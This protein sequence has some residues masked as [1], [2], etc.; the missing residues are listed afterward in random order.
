MSNENELKPIGRS[1]TFVKALLIL[2]T[3][4]SAQASAGAARALSP[5]DGMPTS[6]EIFGYVQDI[7]D[8]G[9]RRTGSQANIETASYIADKFRQAGLTDV[10]I[11]KGKTYQWS[12]TKWGLEAGGVESPAF[13]MRHSF[14]RGQAGPFR[15]PQG[16]LKAPLI[17][18]GNKKDL[19]GIDVKGKIV[20]A[21][22]EL[23]QLDM[24]QILG[25]AT[26]VHDPD[27]TLP[28]GKKLDPFTPNNFPYN[29]ASAMKG[30]AVG[31]VGVLNNYIDSN[32]FYNEDLD[33]F[34]DDKPMNIPG[35]WVTKKDGERLKELARRSSGAQASLVLEGSVD[36]V[37]YRTV[38][39]FLPGRSPET[40]MVQS[41]HDSGFAGAVEDA[42]GTAAVIA[43][44][45][46]Y[47][48]QPPRS[49]KRSL[50]FAVMDTH[51]TGY[52]S[53]VD[54]AKKFILSQAVDVVANVTVEHIAREMVIENGQAKM[55]GLVE[56]RVLLT[57]PSLVDLAGRAI[58][59][60]DY[61]RSLVVGTELFKHEEGIPTDF[62]VIQ[63]LTGIPVISLISA[64]AYLY[65][66]SDTLDKVA[67][68]ELQ[69]TA[70]LA[71]DLLD[72]LDAMPKGTL[73]HDK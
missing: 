15:T 70:L 36:S 68:E 23:G 4:M 37:Q 52:E 9:P 56:P 21:D 44:A 17:Y 66:I 7:T 30:G 34:M 3:T 1:S 6:R 43:L 73:G 53:H 55:T 22:V 62:G 42:S 46:Y 13:Y 57:S 72:G 41:H 32:R 49:R 71:A 14:H 5:H 51:F 18:V 47:G 25:A 31:F 61:R 35:L 38:V 20:V 28:T 39:G 11:E 16:G 10:S 58:K 65:D 27:R 2:A 26:A 69:P 64:P 40:L 48:K 29:V 24:K 19:S 45:K 50:M 63:K 59:K 12:A 8:F 54:L 60:R 67:E 33:Y